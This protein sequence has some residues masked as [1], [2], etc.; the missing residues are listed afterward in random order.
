MVVKWC[1]R[2]NGLLARQSIV[3]QLAKREIFFSET[4]FQLR[5]EVPASVFSLAPDL[6]F[7]VHGHL[8]M[9]TEYGLPCSLIVGCYERQEKVGKTIAHVST[10]LQCYYLSRDSSSSLSLSKSSPLRCMSDLAKLR[11]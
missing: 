8:T 10:S 11:A 3:D 5:C 6:S 1:N 2:A 4:F 9:Q 7:T